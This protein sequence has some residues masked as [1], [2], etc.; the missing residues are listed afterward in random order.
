[1]IMVRLV[2]MEAADHRLALDHFEPVAGHGDRQRKG[3]RAHC[4]A[5]G[6]VA[7]GG[8]QGGLGQADAY[9]AAPAA[10]VAREGHRFLLRR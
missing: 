7:G 2:T 6:A 5:A 1:M 10:A 9:L 8:E 3:A 4:L